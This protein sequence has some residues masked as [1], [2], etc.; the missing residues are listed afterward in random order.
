MESAGYLGLASE[1]LR[2]D[3]T[4]AWQQVLALGQLPARYG[5]FCPL[6]V[7]GHCSACAVAVSLC[8]I[9]PGGQICLTASLGDE[10]EVQ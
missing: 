1:H 7:T 10:M 5:C 3:L 4:S 2:S 6:R 8:A 9:V